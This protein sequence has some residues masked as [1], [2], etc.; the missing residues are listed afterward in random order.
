MEIELP[1]EVGQDEIEAI[2]NTR[3]AQST[4]AKVDR[5]REEQQ[6]A[7]AEMIRLKENRERLNQRSEAR[8][9]AEEYCAWR[10]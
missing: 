3:A 9:R 6:A 4:S 2:I 10:N 7:E 1:A 5:L 8:Q